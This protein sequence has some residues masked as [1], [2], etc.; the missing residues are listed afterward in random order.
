M[1]RGVETLQC[2]VAESVSPRELGCTST[3]AAGI[4]DIQHVAER[5]QGTS[6]LPVALLLLAVSATIG[7]S[8][9]AGF[10]QV[11]TPGNDNRRLED[12]SAHHIGGA[13]GAGQRDGARQA[14][15]AAEG[16]GIDAGGS[17][18]WRRQ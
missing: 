18:W 16:C 6:D 12:M 3:T 11:A 8:H 4:G 2:S 17:F 5:W 13:G 15:G 7:T 9:T 1:R 14:H 10:M